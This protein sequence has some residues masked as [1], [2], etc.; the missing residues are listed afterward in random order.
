M[1]ICCQYRHTFHIDCLAEQPVAEDHISRNFAYDQQLRKGSWLA[2][3][4][5]KGIGLEFPDHSS[6][7]PSASGLLKSQLHKGYN[8]GLYRSPLE[9]RFL[10]CTAKWPVLP[11]T[12]TFKG[13]IKK[14][15]GPSQMGYSRDSLPTRS[16]ITEPDVHRSISSGSPL[17]MT[18]I[19][20]LILPTNASC[21]FARGIKV[22]NLV[23]AISSVSG[24]FIKLF[25]RRLLVNA[26]VHIIY[27]DPWALY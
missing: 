12:N 4:R 9:R 7:S 16:V 8:A 20:P 17:S 6:H 15:Q 26:I 25:V 19:L 24:S 11:P 23:S 21:Q 3:G 1:I 5:L 2:T 13:R 27:E 18:W 14:E 10:Q 22:Y